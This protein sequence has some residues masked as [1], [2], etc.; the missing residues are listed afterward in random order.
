MVQDQ[1]R[2]NSLPPSQ[3]S[4][5]S[6]SPTPKEPWVLFS[7][8]LPHHGAGEGDGVTVGNPAHR[9]HR[10]GLADT[11]TGSSSTTPTSISSTSTSAPPQGLERPMANGEPAV[12]SS[13][14]TPAPLGPFTASSVEVCGALGNSGHWRGGRGTPGGGRAPLPRAVP[15]VPA[16]RAPLGRLHA[17]HPAA[18]LVRGQSLHHV[19]AIGL[20]PPAA[21]KEG[22]RLLTGNRQQASSCPR[23][24]PLL[25]RHPQPVPQTPSILPVLSSSPC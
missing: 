25:S 4:H 11:W 14:G 24:T 15:L 13:S 1:R 12:L 17:A 7:P 16:A 23:C 20:C 21:G 6:P 18:G 8:L 9:C 3:M 22:A 10:C 5:L 19:Q 2:F